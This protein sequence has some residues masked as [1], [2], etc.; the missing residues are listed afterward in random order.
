[1]H[2][3]QVSTFAKIDHHQPANDKKHNVLALRC[4]NFPREVFC[5]SELT[6]AIA[7][8]NL[9]LTNQAKTFCGKREKAALIYLDKVPNELIT[10][11][12]QGKY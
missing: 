10:S 4:E 2:Y 9:G 5:K 11:I 3:L 12:V 8:G 1:M 7:L 6:T